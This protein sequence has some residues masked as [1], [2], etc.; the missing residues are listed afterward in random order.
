MSS[1]YNHQHIYTTVFV[2]TI[3]FVST[4]VLVPP[5]S[6]APGS[7]GSSV[8]GGIVATSFTVIVIASPFF[9]AVPSATLCFN[10]TPFALSSQF[11]KQL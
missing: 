7:L 11:H 8:G 10:T 1:V 5:I 9:N 2:S 3:V 4:T 6:F